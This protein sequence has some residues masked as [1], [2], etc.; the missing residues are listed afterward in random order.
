MIGTRGVPA[1]YG[2]FETAVEEVGR[3]LVE[4]GHQVVV[5]CRGAEDAVNEYL[6]MELVHLPALRRRSLETL[7]HTTLSVLHRALN[8][9]DAAIVFNAAN[10]PLLPVLR[11]RRIPVA[12]HVDGLEWKRSKW[13]P[14]GKRYY[15]VAEE[16]AVRFSDAVIAD[17]DAIADY[18]RHQFGVESRVI[19]YGAPDLAGTGDDG[20]AGLGL[21]ARGYHLVVARFEPENHVLEIVRGYVRSKATRPLVVVGSAPYADA[22]TEAIREAADDRV[23]L[24]GGVWD[25]DLLNQLYANCL[26]YLHGHSVGGTNPSL[27]RA[28]GAAAPTIAFDCIFNREVIGVDGRFF[29]GPRSL[30]DAVEEA[31]DSPEE[32]LELGRRLHAAAKRY[33]WDKVAGSYESLCADLAAGRQQLG[34]AGRRSR[35]PWPGQ[36]EPSGRV[37][38]AHPSAEL[39]GS[40]R[41]LLES[42]CAMIG[43]GSEV[44]VTLPESGPLVDELTRAGAT[45]AI[46]PTPVLRKSG[47]TPKGL[48]KLA[49]EG[50]RFLGPSG[51][52]IRAVDPDRVLVNTVTVPGWLLQAKRAGVSVASHVHEAERAQQP[53]IRRL[54]YAPLFLAD[55]IVVN[56]QYSLNVFGESWPALRRRSEVVYN[57]VIGPSVDLPD[58]RPEPTPARLLFLGRLSPRKGADVAIEAAA[59]LV[60]RGL[61]IRLGMLGAVFD[62]Y[63]WFEQDLHRRVAEGGLGDVV[64]FHG[65]EPNIWDRVAEADIL[66]VPSVVDEPFGNTAVEA[67][68]GGRPVVVSDTSGLREAAA[69][70]KAARMVTPGS[71]EALADGV[72]SVLADW[73]RLR[74]DVVADR[75]EA[76]SRF[77]PARY[78]HDLLA[79]LGMGE[80]SE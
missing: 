18:Y 24:L 17:A 46:L 57:G 73:D 3:R 44:T 13:G 53:W 62:G 64:A 23:K 34:R 38:V 5:F 14:A 26:T 20:L 9:V 52:L 77:A 51:R 72:Q 47:L 30:A 35:A 76:R 10:S 27:L 36:L 28:A 16:L 54:L 45:V 55:R 11:A 37:L 6:G 33:D 39:Y 80:A 49:V 31:E 67:I 60:A 8:G 4:L 56:S 21:E 50:L 79:A 63:E 1:R 42:V 78:H 66:L 15:R 40:D 61:D 2:G 58:P 71:S 7:S 32:F 41:V 19:T 69:G 48:V 68:L 59:T 22:Y 12:T 74:S 75:A 29:G 25:Q 65:F 43:A 70:F